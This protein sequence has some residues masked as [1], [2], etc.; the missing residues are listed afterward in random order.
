MTSVPFTRV[1]RAGPE[2]QFINDVLASGELAGGGRFT[3]LCEAW[4]ADWVGSDHVR[5]TQSC[6]RA[7]D[8]AAILAD[9]EP[10]DEVIMPS[11]TFASTANAIVLRGG[12]PV[13]VDIR[14]DTQNIDETLIEAAITPRTRAITVVH[15]AGV[16]AEMEPILELARRYGLVVFEDAAQA[17]LSRYRGRPAGRL[18]DYGCFSFHQTKNSVAGE[19]GAIVIRDS[20]KAGLAA[21]VAERGTDRHAFRAGSVAHY[22]WVDRGSSFGMNE[23][24]AAFLFA[25]FDK[26][27]DFVAARRTVWDRYHAAFADLEAEGRVHRP[28][29]STS[30]DHNGHLYYLQMRDGD[31]RRHVTEALA[32]DGICAPFHYV[33]LHS[34]PAGRRFGRSVGSLSATDRAGACLMRLPLFAHMPAETVDRVIERVHARVRAAS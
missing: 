17:L 9:I 21:I 33:P 28:V 14:P 24:T 1:T 4:I 31:M 6:T 12:C 34:S 11:F 18:G 19:G 16:C 29:V 25:Q 27:H 2:A 5:L 26:A 30:C 20:E 8:L 13:F 10:G 7:L 22:S 3:R 15:Y 23:L 32:T